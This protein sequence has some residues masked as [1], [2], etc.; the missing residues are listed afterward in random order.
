MF[1]EVPI[2]WSYWMSYVNHKISEL[3]KHLY[4]DQTDDFVL[5]DEFPTLG[6]NREVRNPE[7]ATAMWRLGHPTA[8]WW[9]VPRVRIFLVRLVVKEFLERVP[10]RSLQSQGWHFLDLPS[11]KHPSMWTMTDQGQTCSVV[12]QCHRPR[13]GKNIQHC[14][15]VI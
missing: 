9:K 12:C 4:R 7:W 14:D 2:I 3:Y 6:T 15:C 11:W 5:A 1:Y 13:Q 8:S 10:W